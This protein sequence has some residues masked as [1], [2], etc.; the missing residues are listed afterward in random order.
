MFAARNEADLTGRP[1]LQTTVTEALRDTGAQI[2]L[3][4][5]PGVGKTTLLNYCAADESMPVLFVS[6]Q[7]HMS[8]DDHI[9]AA[10][11]ELVDE[12]QVARSRDRSK[13]RGR[14]L[15]IS[16]PI[17]IRGTVKSTTGETRR[18]ETVDRI[19][20]L[21]L[22]DA[23]QKTGHRII[24]FDNFHNVSG[25]ERQP[26]AQA[27]E[28]LSDRA[29]TTG[30]IKIALLGVT[31]D[32]QTLV[33]TSGSVGRRLV[34]IGVPR[35]PDRGIEEIIR[36]GFG[37]LD[38]TWTS[39]QLARMT[40]FSDGFPFFAHLLGLTISRRAIRDGVTAIEDSFVRDAL[41]IAVQSVEASYRERVQAAMAKGKTERLRFGLITTLL[42]SRRTHWTT[43]QIV[44]QYVYS[45]WST[46]DPA[47]LEPALSQ[48]VTADF[49]A[50]L[51]RSGRA[52]DFTYRFADPYARLCALLSAFPDGD[53]LG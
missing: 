12:R 10:I 43:S 41:H 18:F 24:A 17:T 38:L 16:R 53:P 29:A 49:G 28:T 22:V 7:T 42:R 4:G 45:S 11:R 20:L 40:F 3:Y 15:G 8:F 14:T 46:T 33:A 25:E 37:L 51:T 39:R 35:M 36:T 1:D 44:G 48:L 19:P 47:D 27:I 13:N 6:C 32:A 30:D 9:D 21:A 34:Q 23:M 50:L 52:G 5:D 31:Q 2:L 26:F